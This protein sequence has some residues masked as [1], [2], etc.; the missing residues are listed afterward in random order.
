[1]PGVYT[2]LVFDDEADQRGSYALDLEAVSESLT[3][4][5]SIACG[6]RVTATLAAGEVH[7]YTF[8]APMAGA[9]APTIV[10]LTDIDAGFEACLELYSPSG[11][12]LASG[13]Y[14]IDNGALSMPGVYTL[15]VFDDEAD[16]RGSYAL[17]FEAVSESLTC[18]QSVGC[19]TNR[20]EVLSELGQVDGYTF[21]LSAPAALRLKIDQVSAIDPGFFAYGELYGPSGAFLGPF[22]DWVEVLSP[23][24]YTILVFDDES[25]QRGSYRLRINCRTR[26]RRL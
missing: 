16:Q 15:L 8:A 22:I 4:G 21:E 6:Q 25:D 11:A 18:G 12:L 14:G 10:D 19:G 23:G 9:I 20:V 13:C 26:P 5:D 17:D 1:M 2:L 3:C 24:R 7:A